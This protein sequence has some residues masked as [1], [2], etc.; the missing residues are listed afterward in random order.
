MK[1]LLTI[2]AA[3]ILCLSTADGAKPRR[4]SNSVRQQQQQT[5]RQI[6]ETNE[7][8]RRNEQTIT[9]SLN[10]LNQLQSEIATCNNAITAL[11][12][13]IDS[14]QAETAIV[15]DSVAKLDARLERM[16]SSFVTALRNSRQNRTSMGNLAFIF[17]SDSFAQAFRRARALK[18]FAKWRRRKADEI[19]S[20]RSLLDERKLYL[21]SLESQSRTAVSDLAA[22]RASLL[23]KQKETD[24][25]ITD[26]KGKGKQLRRVLKQQRDKATALDKELDRLIAEEQK[27]AEKKRK[28]EEA[29][30]RKRE[31]ERIA[32]EEAERR[33]QQQAAEEEKTQPAKPD[34]PA[35]RKPEQA[36]PAKPSDTTQTTPIL[37]SAFGQNKGKL[38]SPVEGSYTI[39]KHFGRSRHPM[40]RQVVTE[41]SGID[42]QTSPG[43][44]VRSVFEGQVSAIFCPDGY[45]NV[46]V[47]RH[48]NYATVYANLGSLNVR[49]GDKVKLGQAIGSVYIDTSDNNRSILH[50]EIRNASNPNNVRKE[51]PEE[52][53]K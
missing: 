1:K 40:Y 38:P 19:A 33:R 24:S 17:S 42:I 27:A 21:D 28:R 23:S 32:R 25:I 43:A 14:I 13:R 15:S 20:I 30:A 2:I 35:D 6:R 7:Q 50:F 41:N 44:T 26:L 52:W 46:V 47:I 9:R 39:V 5:A 36:K 10:Q 18:Q 4:N 3:I 48:G 11:T 31:Q 16:K 34:K 22:Q 45:N 37:G 29:E 53:I 51:N 49:K 8:I 12:A